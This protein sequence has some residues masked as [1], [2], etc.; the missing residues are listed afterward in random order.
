MYPQKNR[1]PRGEFR[2][3]FTVG[4]RLTSYDLSILTSP[5]TQKINRFA[6]VVGKTVHKHAVVRNRIKRLIRESLSHL[7]IHFLPGHDSI[8][9]VK[10][11][12]SAK[13]QVEVENEI[14]TLFSRLHLFYNKA[15]QQ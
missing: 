11:D 9:I 8:I 3:V 6:V 2:R 12:I 1:L 15:M 14:N 13:K 5:N 7:L 4:T 10:R